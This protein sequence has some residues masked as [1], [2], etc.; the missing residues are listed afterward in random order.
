MNTPQE[1]ESSAH[2]NIEVPSNLPAQIAPVA[3]VSKSPDLSASTLP[4]TSSRSEAQD[5]S[6]AH[7]TKKK[8]K[9]RGP[10]PPKERK[11]RLDVFIVEKYVKPDCVNFPRDIKIAQKLI[12]KCPEPAFWVWMPVLRTV[13]SMALLYTKKCRNFL[14]IRHSQWIQELKRNEKIIIVDRPK[15]PIYNEVYGTPVELDDK[16]KTLLDFCK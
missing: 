16:P 10:A 5:V 4:S 2:A 8:R 1:S 15:I 14:K 9:P 6:A 13:E 11:F 12:E 7:T 3:L